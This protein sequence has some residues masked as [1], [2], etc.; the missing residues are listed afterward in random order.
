MENKKCLECLSPVKGRSDKRFCNDACRSSY[1]NRLKTDS[2]NIVRKINKQLHKNRRILS[3]LLK[4]EK[5]IRV[6]EDRLLTL[7]FDLEY[8]THDLQTSKG[9]TYFFVYEYGYLSLEN[10]QYLIVKNKNLI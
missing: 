6:N 5:M 4:E 3:D 1:N 9:Q 7:G 2:S 8:H 10:Q